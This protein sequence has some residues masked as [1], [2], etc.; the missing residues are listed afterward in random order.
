MLNTSPDIYAG[1]L[2]RTF[3]LDVNTPVAQ[4]LGAIDRQER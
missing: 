2:A 1:L 3:L 4:L